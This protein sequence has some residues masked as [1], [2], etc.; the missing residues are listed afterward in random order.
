MSDESASHPGGIHPAH[1]R[2][3]QVG[4][5]VLHTDA[6]GYLIDRSEWSEDF[7]R[8]LAAKEGVALTDEHWQVIRFLRDHFRLKGRQ[9]PIPQIIKHF[10]PLWGPERAN[11]GHL[12]RLF[13]AG[14]GADRLGYR[15]AGIGRRKGEG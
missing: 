6:E 12:F 14:G 15:L 11:A 7:A 1:V 5:Q 8:A 10:R 2:T 9:A 3:I 4:G 13:E